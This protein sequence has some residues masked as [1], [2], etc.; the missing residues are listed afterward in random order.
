MCV[1]ATRTNRSGRGACT[2]PRT[3]ASAMLIGRHGRRP[4]TAALHDESTEFAHTIE[5][6][7]KAPVTT[8]SSRRRVPTA[9]RTHP[10][11]LTAAHS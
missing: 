5:R 8:S 3:T 4:G 9:S 2:E 1:C 10:F 11:V 7:K 6:E